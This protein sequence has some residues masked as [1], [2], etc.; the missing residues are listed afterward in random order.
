MPADPSD[1]KQWWL[2]KTVWLNVLLFV[3][4]VATYFAAPEHDPALTM[5]SLSAAVVGVVNVAL[6][7]FFTAA[8]I[9]GTPLAAEVHRAR[10]TRLIADRQ[11][12]TPA[13]GGQ[14][15]GSA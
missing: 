1:P 10:A 3:G 5:T 14:I 13:A 12:A 8:P 9:A 15:G 6:R 7:V 2:S 11:P 4:G